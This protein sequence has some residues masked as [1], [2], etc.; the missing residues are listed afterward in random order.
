MSVENGVDKPVNPDEADTAL[1]ESEMKKFLSSND[2]EPETAV[3][4]GGSNQKVSLRKAFRVGSS[5]KLKGNKL[6]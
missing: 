6:N 4:N 5:D 1:L 2:S 3:I